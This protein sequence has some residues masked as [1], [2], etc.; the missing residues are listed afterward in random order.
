M[1][2]NRGPIEHERLKELV[3]LAATGQLSA[4]EYAEV[5]SHVKECAA[6]RAEY[7]DFAEILLDHFPLIDPSREH[8][9]GRLWLRSRAKVYR[10]R[11]VER[12][13]E[14]GCESPAPVAQES[15]RARLRASTTALPAYALATIA[16]L[17]LGAGF[18]G[19]G[20]HHASTNERARA[21]ALARANE[22][23][24]RLQEQL[25]RPATSAASGADSAGA[26]GETALADLRAKY[27][28]LNARN[29]ALKEQLKNALALAQTLQAESLAD[30]DARGEISGQLQQAQATI[31]QLTAQL[32]GLQQR[33]ADDADTLG[34]SRA[35]VE[36][37]EKDLAATQ[38]TLSRTQRLLAADRDIRELMG[39]R[40]LQ[41]TDVYD[42]DAKGRRRKAFGRVFFTQGK[43][44]IFYAFDLSMA[45]P[46]SGEHSY[47]AWGYQQA[48]RKTTQSL[49]VLYLDDQRQNRWV[50][51]FDNP[52]ALE[53]IDAVFITVEPPGGSQKPTG[54][55]LL[56]AYLGGGVNHP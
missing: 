35:R 41:I 14:E 32:G 21:A 49:G 48:A 3:A 53:E 54:Q 26:Q 56:F 52:A 55:K 5:R 33:R 11:F 36:T 8:L 28:E 30:K 27:A 9:P 2:Q 51:K 23:N 31:S 22:E 29:L 20:W 19:Y 46:A 7:S 16:V 47:Q 12:L 38:E 42:V 40:D 6:C 1:F 50:L 18:L 34:E 4:D 13:R 25:A 37:L 45:K 39:A 44:L 10:K 24:A 17:I 43:S 15:F